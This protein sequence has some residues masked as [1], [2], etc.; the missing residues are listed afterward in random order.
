VSLPHTDE[1]ITMNSKQ[2]VE[3]AIRFETPPRLPY[4]FPEEYGSDII[5][6][7]VQP[8]PDAM[9]SNGV[10]A[11]GAVWRNIGS[12]DKG[13]V[14]E[15]PLKTWDDLPYLKAPD[16]KSPAL[17]ASLDGIREQA[18]DRFI[19]GS[20]ISLYERVKCIRG[21]E[22]TWMDIYDHRDALCG[23]I[24]LILEMNLEII[25]HFA[26]LGIHGFI[27]YDDWGL[28][29]RL[30]ISPEQ[31]REIWKPRYARLYEAAHRKGL[32]TFLHSCG[33]IVEILDDLIEVGLDVIQMDQQENMGLELLG[34]RFGGRITF[35]SP[36]DIQKT[37]AQ[38]NVDDI[39]RYCR[40]M[41]ATLGRPTGG[42]IPKSYTDIAGAGYS[43]E[44]LRAMC[45]EFLTISQEFSATQCR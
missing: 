38:G 23:L 28:Q 36:V 18:G 39:R 16:I 43:Q 27:N 13:E 34:E 25:D 33:Y 5:Y 42:F 2:I 37:M 35:Y 19:I 41:A 12:S 45:E 3:A 9:L 21:L 15:H 17:W 32:Y 10:D 7:Y 31:W 26:E 6:A 30:S 1:E 4:D 20:G 29:D 24:D 22:A 8:H 44:S 14:Q 40:R 11:W